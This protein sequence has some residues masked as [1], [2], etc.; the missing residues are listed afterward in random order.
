VLRRVH[1]DE[2]LELLADLDGPGDRQRLTV[3]RQEGAPEPYHRIG[4][5]DEQATAWT[6]PEHDPLPFLQQPDRLVDR[7]PGDAG[8]V[9]QVGPGAYVVTRSQAALVDRALDV[10]DDILRA[11]SVDR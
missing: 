7:C 8:L 2:R 9:A 6:R 4:L 3:H 10:D 5:R 11:A 1:R